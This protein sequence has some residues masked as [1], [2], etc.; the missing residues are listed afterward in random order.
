MYI[1]SCNQHTKTH[2]IKTQNKKK[3]HTQS[4]HKTNKRKTYTQKKLKK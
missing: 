4:Q 1:Y 3:K 2:A